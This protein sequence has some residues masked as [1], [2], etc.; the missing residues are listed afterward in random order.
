MTGKPLARSLCTIV[1]GLSLYLETWDERPYVALHDGILYIYT[2]TQ[3]TCI[4]LVLSRHMYISY[5]ICPRKHEC[6]IGSIEH[7]FFLTMS[8]DSIC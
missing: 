8:I 1:G 6:L 7:R 5:H 4:S 3:K 2:Y